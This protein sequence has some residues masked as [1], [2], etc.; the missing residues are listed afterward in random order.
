MLVVDDDVATQEAIAEV[1]REMGAEVKVAHSA[2][3]A[4]I[5]VEEFH[6]QPCSVTS[7]CPARTATTSFAG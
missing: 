2:A 3:E 6:P 7:R 4:M 5:A 1:L